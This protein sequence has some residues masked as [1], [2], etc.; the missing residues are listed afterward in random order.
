MSQVEAGDTGSRETSEKDGYG[1][2]RRDGRFMQDRRDTRDKR[3]ARNR[4][5]KK[6]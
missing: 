5:D 2:I 6:I 4:R 1:C 3:E